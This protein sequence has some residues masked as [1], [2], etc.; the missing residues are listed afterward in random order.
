[1][2][3]FKVRFVTSAYAFVNVEAEDEEAAQ[4]KAYDHLPTICANCSGWGKDGISLE[5]DEFEADMNDETIP[6]VEPI[7]DD[8]KV[9]YSE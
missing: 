9:V 7:D 8:E 6:C 1:M 5:I 4:E 3:K 2:P